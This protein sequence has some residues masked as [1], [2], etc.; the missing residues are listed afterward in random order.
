MPGLDDF[1]RALSRRIGFGKA[2][3]PAWAVALVAFAGV[4][5]WRRKHAGASGAST[6]VVSGVA[7]GAGTGTGDFS[8]GG[9][10]DSGGGGGG[11]GDL[12]QPSPL[13]D[14]AA[15]AW[16]DT[17]PPWW[18]TPPETSTTTQD[19][20]TT[21]ATVTAT[22]AQSKT[23]LPGQ[24]YLLW[25]GQK[26]KTQAE[27]NTW[28]SKHGLSLAKLAGSHPQAVAVY[29]SL[30]KGK[31]PTPAI[32]PKRGAP[33]SKAQRQQQKASRPEK[34]RTGGQ[35]PTHAAAPRARHRT[36]PT[37]ARPAG[38]AR[39]ASVRSVPARVVKVVQKVLHP[40]PAKPR[41]KSSKRTDIAAAV[42]SPKI[43][44]PG[45]EFVPG[46]GSPKVVRRTLASVRPS[47]RTSTPSRQ[48]VAVRSAAAGHPAATPGAAPPPQRPQQQ[49]SSAPA[50]R[51]VSTAPTRSGPYSWGR[52]GKQ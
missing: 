28:L 36:A 41:G 19:P 15:P 10:G 1:K 12:P 16:W 31:A 48:T 14:S 18:D 20:G 21:P 6:G 35:A 25:G 17:P 43:I 3:A 40:A 11:G 33:A 34:G 47:A 46:R 13:P 42:G 26:F 24:G 5:W 29:R 38:S 39:P 52:G 51:T 49:R 37:P 44:V 2:K 8:G 7:A 50:T 22:Q 9:S 4:W 23:Q 30:P 32:K 45:P 27:F